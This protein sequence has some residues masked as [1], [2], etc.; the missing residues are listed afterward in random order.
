[1]SHLFVLGPNASTETAQLRPLAKA[2]TRVRVKYKPAAK[3]I[4]LKASSVDVCEA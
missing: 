4:A 1:M 3:L 2:Q